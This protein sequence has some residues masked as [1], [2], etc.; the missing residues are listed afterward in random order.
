[1]QEVTTRIREKGMC[2][3]GRMEKKDRIKTL[4]TER[5]ANIN[6]LCINK[7]LLFFNKDFIFYFIY[8]QNL[9]VFTSFCA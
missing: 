7:L 9:D 1:M 6:T 8:V 3:Q 2:R 4:D 5:Y